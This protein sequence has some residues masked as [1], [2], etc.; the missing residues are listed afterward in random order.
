MN[1]FLNHIGTQAN[2]ASSCTNNQKPLTM[3]GWGL[4]AIILAIS[5][6]ACGDT[7]D[8]DLRNYVNE[9]KARK[10]GRIPPLP[11]PKKFEIFAY[12]DAAM[13]DPFVSVQ[14]I[15][16]AANEGSGLRPD[17]AREKDVLEGYALGSMKMMGS[18]EKNGNLWALI[19]APDG[20]LHRTIKG[21]HMGRNHG[22]IVKITESK[23]ELK[24]IVPD[25]LGGWIE[26][27]STLAASE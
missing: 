19:R 4:L 21:R 6:T 18:L 27:F 26:R 11:E 8:E 5:L 17:A 1:I 12:N 13:R 2:P 10:K 20:T 15:E 3:I 9:F 7:Q 16:A 25:G 24:E 22:E 14:V 23:L